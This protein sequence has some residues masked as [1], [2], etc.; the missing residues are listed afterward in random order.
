MDREAWSTGLQRV[1]HDWACRHT[2]RW[3]GMNQSRVCWYSCALWNRRPRR[4][5]PLHSP[6]PGWRTAC[7]PLL[8][9]EEGKNSSVV[10]KREGSTLAPLCSGSVALCTQPLGTCLLKYKWGC[11]LKKTHSLKAESYV[12]FGGHNWGLKPGTKHSVALRAC[13]KEVR[14]EPGHIGVFATKTR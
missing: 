5:V 9:A 13:S 2:Q 11:G 7:W 12:L 8:P 14:E 4:P 10:T 1:G 3:L 6:G